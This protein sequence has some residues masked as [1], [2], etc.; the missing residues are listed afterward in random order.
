MEEEIKRKRGRPPKPKDVPKEPKPP[1]PKQ[2]DKKTGQFVPHDVIQTDEQI[3]EYNQS[4]VG[5]RMYSKEA[6]SGE[7]LQLVV[8]YIAREI[9]NM[10][11]RINLRDTELVRETVIRYMRSCDKYGVMPTQLGLARACGI[12]RRGLSMFISRHP[13]S[14]SAQLL[15]SVLDAFSEALTQA[16]LNGSVQPIVGI[17]LQKA[18]YGLRETDPVAQPQE[19]P[20][21]EA[22]DTET[23]MKKYEELTAGE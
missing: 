1:K 4:L 8:S 13:E 14:P 2:Q 18:L 17:F 11:Q 19:S 20:I 9:E 7:K 10:P 22:T 5:N 21:G 12:D 23:L 15:S 6:D 3:D 16:S